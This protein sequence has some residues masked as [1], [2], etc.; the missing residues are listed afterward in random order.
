MGIRDH[1]K[2]SERGEG[3]AITEDVSDKDDSGL[4]VLGAGDVRRET[5]EAIDDLALP[6]GGVQRWRVRTAL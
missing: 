6:A 3:K 2:S 1:K 5:A 4:G